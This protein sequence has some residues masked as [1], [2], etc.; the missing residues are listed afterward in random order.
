[1]K[2]SLKR[3]THSTSFI[4]EIDG[5]RFFAI[6]TVVLF[7]LNTSLSKSLGFDASFGIDAL[8]GK[9]DMLQLGWW[10]VR[11]DLGVKVF[12]AISGF[13]LA[14]PFL[15]YGLLGEG[16]KVSIG[17]Y[18]VRRLTR[19]EP[20]FIISLIVFLFVHVLIRHET[21]NEMSGHFFAGLVYL[22]GFIFGEPN[23]IN[24]VTWSLEVEAQFYVLVPMLFW[25]IFRF[26][27]QL[28]RIIVILVLIAISV[29]AKNYIFQIGSERLM[30][31]ILSYFT[32]FGVGLL[33]AYF[34]VL[35]HKGWLKIKSYL[36]DLLGILC[37]LGV[38]YFY[39]PQHQILNNVLFNV[40]VFGIMV[41]AFKGKIW[42]YFYTRSWVY[43][44]GGM[45]YSIYLLHYAFFH[46][47]VPYTSKI[48]LNMGYKID[49]GIQILVAVPIMLLVS[50]VFYIL[51]ERPCMDKDWPKKFLKIKK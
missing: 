23:P 3:K 17:P 39:K 49:Y 7:H 29:F 24:P 26:K 44:I 32:N 2:L 25:L 46:L 45:C 9:Y 43:I 50:T 40:S 51:I 13:V 35:D 38:F 6:I 16:K 30:A 11:L 31:S 20:P 19:L 33:F 5:L 36:F 47:L 14:L 15:K 18:F 34:F 42:N 28:T 4:P 10:V 48:S 21:L 37:V 27:N 8:G 41:T 12:F 1:M 22:H